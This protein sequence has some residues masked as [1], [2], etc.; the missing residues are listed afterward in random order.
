M[1]LKSFMS[2][3]V[4]IF[5]ESDD[6]TYIYGDR[7]FKA[8]VNDGVVCEPYYLKDDD[9]IISFYRSQGFFIVYVNDKIVNVIYTMTCWSDDFAKYTFNNGI[10][11]E[12]FETSHGFRNVTVSYENGMTSS[13]TY[14]GR[15]FGRFAIGRP[16]PDF[17]D[18]FD[19]YKLPQSIIDELDI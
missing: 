4:D 11:L 2:M 17:S 8:I 18:F 13:V 6:D 16:A 10:L 15:K 19:K 7:N 12:L 3:F 5:I 14:R 1:W 9:K